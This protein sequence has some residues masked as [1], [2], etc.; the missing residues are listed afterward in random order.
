[1][2]VPEF[3]LA[4]RS[5]IGH[6]PLP[7]PGVT[8]VVLDDQDRVLL[9]RRAD[10]GLWAL[11]TGCLEPGEQPA[12]GALREVLEE[13]GVEAAVDRL[14]NVEAL[15]LS[16][17]PNGDQVYWLNLT[18]RCRA[19]RGEARVNDDESTAVGWFALNSLPALTARHTRYLGQA[20]DDASEPWFVR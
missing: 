10:N 2:P 9:V 20:L 16:A 18:F 11:V 13:T 8:A 3:V 17:C 6:H 14:V 12:V 1:M 4:L 5:K 19:V 7:L 15:E